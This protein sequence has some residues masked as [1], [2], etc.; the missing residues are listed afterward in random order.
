MIPG[1]T[2]DI[3][4]SYRQKDNKGNRWVSKFV[5]TLKT[6]LETTFKEDISVY[7]DE[8]PDDRLQE[9]HDIEKS[10]ESKLKCLIFI[11]I[12]S[13]TYCDPKSYAWQHEFLAFVKLSK[14]DRTWQR[15][16]VKK[17]ELRQP[18]SS[19]TDK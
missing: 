10:L 18:D 11:P 19:C 7:F 13:Q 12:L 9:N 5:D 1:F 17:R 6:E 8:N 4:I 3:F 16:K 14:E 2:Y 15:C